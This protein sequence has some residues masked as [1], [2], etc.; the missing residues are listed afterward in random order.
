MAAL[1]M[2]LLA[3]DARTHRRDASAPAPIVVAVP[4][5]SDPVIGRTAQTVAEGLASMG[6]GTVPTVAVADGSLEA[7]E[8]MALQRRAGLVV[9]LDA[10][11][12]ELEGDA[13][14]VEVEDRGRWTGGLPGLG[15]TFVRLGGASKL[16]DQYAA[17]EFMRRMGAR[18]FHPE[19]EYI[20]QID[21]TTARARA[22]TPTALARKRAN[23]TADPVYRPDFEHRSFSFHSAHPLAIGES[24]SDAEHPIDEALRVHDWIVKNRG[25][26]TKE[27]MRGTATGE[28]RTRRLAELEENRKSLGLRRMVGITLHNLQQGENAALS[29]PAS[30]G[31]SA[32]ARIEAEVARRLA[33]A[34]DTVAFGVHFGTTEFTTTPDRTTV[35]QLDQVSEAVKRLRPDLAVLVNAHITG[36]Q[37]T[38]HFDDRGCPTGTNDRG[39][40]DYYDLGFHTRAGVGVRVHTVMF[41]PLEGPAHVYNQRSFSHKLCLMERASAQGRPLWYFPEGS[42]W[43]GFDNSVPVYLPLYLWARK[44]D[45]EL[46][47]PLLRR[48]GGTLEG[49]RMFDS[50]HEWGYWQQ[51]YGVGLW[52][53]NVDVSLAAV[54]AELADPLCPSERWEQGCPAKD[55]FV[56]VLEQTIA[57]QR[58]MFLEAQDFRGRPGG[59]YAYFAGEEPADVAAAGTGMEFR[60]VRLAFDGVLDLT[61]DQVDALEVDLQEL[62]GAEAAYRGWVQRLEAHRDSVLA[63]GLPWLDEVRDGLEINGLR[64]RQAVQL[65]RI[66]LDLRSLRARGASA[67]E[68]QRSVDEGLREAKLTLEA[69]RAVVRRRE[70][71][72]RYAPEKLY[73]GGVTAQTAVPNGTTY[74]FR[75]HTKTHLMTYWSNRHLEVEAMGHRLAGDL[76]GRLRIE[77]VFARPGEPVE[78]TWS[79]SPGRIGPVGSDSEETGTDLKIPSRRGV[80]RFLATLGPNQEPLPG[81]V[82][83]AD[84]LAATRRGGVTLSNPSSPL[85]HS[86]IGNLMPAFSWA[87]A[88][89]PDGA[90]AFGMTKRDGES[91]TFRD[92]QV[93]GFAR[94]GDGFRTE[95][96]PFSLPLVSRNGSRTLTTLT[97][98]DAVISGAVT[99]GRL[100]PALAMEGRLTI[101]PIVKALVDLAGFDEAGARRMLAGV[102]GFDASRPPQ[103]V[104]FSATLTLDEDPSRG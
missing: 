3:T 87:I 102:L 55:A 56:E 30:G 36:A 65:Y 51:D 10:A 28:R 99:G 17:Y 26:L 47:E 59:L 46:L 82:V 32:A 24:F 67:Q 16:A 15:A 9:A 62:Q 98:E 72:Y 42:W 39:R 80:H 41:Y 63:P 14:A 94:W 77:P 43:L 13:F 34:P 52:H 81:V 90:L 75:V 79:G 1:A 48:R 22:R 44:R 101:Q 64:A 5:G 20:P 88:G 35:A 66:A 18:Y 23:G 19:Q 50:G 2:G 69:A 29:D 74:P 83:R 40:G 57:H 45:V 104:P 60:P 12:A 96:V 33:Q 91:P 21:A 71:A 92:I 84:L 73:G 49:H 27:G 6:L 78:I 7:L 76:N 58:R 103:S 37:P 86:V 70:G 85:V 54:L 93:A 100:G 68:I 95:P 97:V 53:F 89:G 61:D 38:P 8:A 4:A 11:G 25:D 31:E